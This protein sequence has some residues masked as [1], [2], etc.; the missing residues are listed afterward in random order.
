VSAFA[1]FLIFGKILYN[2]IVD[3][4]KC[5]FINLASNTLQTLGLQIC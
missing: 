3:K 1:G 2:I 4:L 5:K